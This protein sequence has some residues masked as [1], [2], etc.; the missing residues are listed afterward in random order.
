MA[1]MTTAFDVD[2]PLAILTFNRPEARN[3]MTWEMY[4]ALVAGVRPR[5][6]RSW[7]PR[8]RSARRRRQGV[9]VGHGHR[10]VS[11]LQNA[12]GRSGVRKAAGR[13][14]GPPRATDEAGHRA[15]R[16]RRGRRRLRDR[17]L[18]RPAHR[19]A[20]VHIRRADCAHARQL[21]FGRHLQ[22]PRRSDGSRPGQGNVCSRAAC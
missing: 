19:D 5:G 7:T 12:R 6:Q 3:A 2:G 8:A 11:G 14:A 16:R 21:P 20:G 17:G 10:A 1:P 9:R 4:D 13:R 15:D 22:P 18:L